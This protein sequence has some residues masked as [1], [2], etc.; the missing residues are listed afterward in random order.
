MITPTAGE[1]SVD[2]DTLREFTEF[3]KQGGVDGLFP[4]GTTGEFTALGR[5]QRQTV[6]KTVVDTSGDVPVLAGCGGTAVSSVRGYIADAADASAD[7]AVVVTPYYQNGSQAS[8]RRFYEAVS[9]DSPLP[10][11][12]YNI[13]QF[14]GNHPDP[15]T[16]ANLAEHPNIVGIK[17]S[18]GEFNF[19]M[20]LLDTAPPSFDVIQGIPTYS[21]MSLKH[22]ADGLIA[23]PANVFPE[24]V[25]ELYAAHQAGDD[26][27][28]W[29]RLSEV[30]LPIL[31]TTR[32]M[33]MISALR[34]L[35]ANAG[36]DLGDPLPPLP[37]LT[38]NQREKLDR[39]YRTV[40][41]S[42][43]TPEDD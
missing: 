4:V 9:L 5:D 15:E 35:S 17:D 6:V 39:C 28:A 13:P 29:A 8:L 32:S 18:S 22:G 10:I 14:T 43:L 12:L 27:Y 33:P 36:R 41:A 2:T 40:V 7:A 21:L 24:A 25:S 37:E 30:I 31:R 1:S 16:V 34:Y 3:L 38:N 23:G 19:F 20:N 42:E 26:A 11:Y